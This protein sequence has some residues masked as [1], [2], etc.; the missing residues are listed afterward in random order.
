MQ[1][2]KDLVPLAAGSSTAIAALL[3]N[4]EILKMIYGDALQPS[5]KNVGKALET[6]FGLG[7]TI[8]LPLQLLNEKTN[9]LFRKHMENYKK[10]LENR[11]ESEICEVPS[12]IGNPIIEKL[13][14]IQDE[15]IS[16]MF[17]SLLENASL[18]NFCTKVH[19]LFI[20]VINN[21]TP[22]DAILI[23][24]IVFDYVKKGFTKI[25]YIYI[26]SIETGKVGLIN[27]TG[28]IFSKSILIGLRNES[29][30]KLYIDNLIALGLFYKRDDQHLVDIETFYK[31]IEDE[32]KDE[33]E[34]I[35]IEIIKNNRDIK[36]GYG[37][38]EISNTGQ[39]FI[40][41]IGF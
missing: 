33:I 7:N 10:R 26:K 14:Y 31:P 6:V 36:I 20:H 25:P 39:V 41:S 27:I 24:N 18:T 4:P 23:K 38:L 40:D 1:D 2:V 19:P 29:N 8:L 22:D 5:V 3:K 11:D 12:E 35:K 15:N 32:Y 13:T 37:L 16:N 9:A 28:C 34:Q 21:L 17:I 30:Y